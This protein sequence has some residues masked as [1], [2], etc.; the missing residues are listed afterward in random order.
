MHKC[1]PLEYPGEWKDAQKD[2]SHSFYHTWENCHAMNL[3][4]GYKTYLYVF[5]KENVK[6]ICPVAER[7]YD[8]YIDI[9]TP[10]GF[11]GFT[12]NK[13]FPDFINYWTEFAVKKKYI[14]GYISM[15][16]FTSSESYFNKKDSYISTNL[17][18]IDLSKSLTD[19]YENL[20]ANRRK[21]IKDFKKAEAGFIYD[22]DRLI[23][24][25]KNNYY[26]FLKRINASS[27]NY[28][29]AETLEF[30]CSLENV[31]MVGAG[32][33]DYIEAV[34][35]FAYTE[36]EGIS[37]FNV[38]TPEGRR[39]SPLLLWSGLKFFRSKKIPVMNLGGGIKEDD[40]V[41]LSKERFGAYKLPFI[42][43]RQIYDADIYDRLC[44][45]TGTDSINRSGYFPAY[46]K[47]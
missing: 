11:S 18:F 4:T 37:M 47:N 40:S 17:Y 16:P 23:K 35:I 32:S 3:T 39:H 22:R 33:R 44:R 46:R 36:Y 43:L 10:Y 24:F 6:I 14:C 26:G 8:G 30:I 31:Y 7:E 1:I 21:Q 13:D 15:N 25:F 9:T 29:S 28:F 38:A 5:E 19:I 12:G 45:E 34:Y 41:A 27:A 20:D 2:I 42:N